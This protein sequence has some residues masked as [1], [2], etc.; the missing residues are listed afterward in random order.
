M[1]DIAPS[2]YAIRGFA[3]AGGC[4][5]STYEVHFEQLAAL[6]ERWRFTLSSWQ[7]LFERRRFSWS[8]WQARIEPLRRQDYAGLYK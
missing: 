2:F 3:P 5:R 6:I 4:F 8:S 1:F 7:P